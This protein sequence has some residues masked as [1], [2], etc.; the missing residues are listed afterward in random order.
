MIFAREFELE[1][2]EYVVRETRKHWFVFLL[3]LLPYA[4]LAVLPFALPALL[5]LA[6][7]LAP[8]SASF[9]YAEPAARVV[10][11]LWL[12]MVWTS[13]WGRFTR[14][15]LNVWVLT[16]ER[17]VAVKQRAYFRREVSSLFLARVQDVTTHVSGILSSLLNIGT[18]NVQSAGA[19]EKFTMHDIPLPEQMRDL[20]LEHVPEPE[21]KSVGAV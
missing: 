17:I 3:E 20:I 16:N 11:G 2:D 7:P 13:A 9:D 5:S 18:I 10:L 21:Q 12:L 6:P 15:Y 1:P 4:I 19:V 8:F 14:Y